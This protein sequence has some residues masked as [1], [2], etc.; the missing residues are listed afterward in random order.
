MGEGR[1]NRIAARIELEAVDVAIGL[2]PPVGRRRPRSARPRR[3]SLRPRRSLRTRHSVWTRHSIGTRRSRR[4][5][6]RPAAI[7]RSAGSHPARVRRRVRAVPAPSGSADPGDEVLPLVIRRPSFIITKNG[8]F[9]SANC[10]R[11]YFV[12]SVFGSRS[13][14]SRQIERDGHPETARRLTRQR[15]SGLRETVQTNNIACTTSIAARNATTPNAD[16]PVEA[17]VPLHTKNGLGI[18]DSGFAAACRD[19]IKKASNPLARLQKIVIANPN[20]KSRIP[21][22]SQ[23]FHCRRHGRSQIIESMPT[24]PAAWSST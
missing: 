2:L 19:F 23:S 9:T 4:S 21:A 22:V 15:A 17:S 18:R 3:R 1:M 10:S 20:P 16:P 7:H 5:A 6:L 24:A 12:R 8:W 14:A 11:T 13:S